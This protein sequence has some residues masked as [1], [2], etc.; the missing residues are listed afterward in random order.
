MRDAA[1]SSPRARGTQPLAALVR[2]HQRFIPASAGN[3]QASVKNAPHETVHPRER[4]ERSC[5]SSSRPAARGSSPRAR[6]TPWR[7]R[8]RPAHR[9]FI[10]ASAGN[11]F[12]GSN[13][14]AARAVHP[15]ERGERP[16]MRQKR[17][18]ALGSSPRARG[19]P[20]CAL[21]RL[22]IQRFIPASAGNASPV[23]RSGS[24]FSV[25]PRERGERAPGSR[26]VQRAGGSSPR[27][28]GTRAYR[29]SGFRPGR[30]IPASA[31]NAAQPL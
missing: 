11:A 23:H 21:A 27:A 8:A 25:H 12:P 26:A 6:G 31:G 15:R 14:V 17:M 7:A 5:P 1:G 20:T 28:R 9:R 30:F 24:R 10:P 4:G 19:T 18:A 29:Y 16:S 22:S 3:A 2:P 13:R